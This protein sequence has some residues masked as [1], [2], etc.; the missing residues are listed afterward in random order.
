[1]INDAYELIYHAQ[2]PDIPY[3]IKLS[4]AGNEKIQI[5]Y[6]DD[7]LCGEFKFSV[8]RLLLEKFLEVIK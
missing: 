2:D 8:S 3:R 6:T 4:Y 7:K 5:S 1:M